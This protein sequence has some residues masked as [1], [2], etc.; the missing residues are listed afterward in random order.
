MPIEIDDQ[1]EYL[2]KGCVDV[3]PVES[4]IGPLEKR[5]G[6]IAAKNISAFKRAFEE[7]EIN[8]R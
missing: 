4:L 7:T 3:V 6:R 5:F 2:I 1:L 8:R